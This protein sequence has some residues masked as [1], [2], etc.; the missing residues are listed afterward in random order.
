MRRCPAKAVKGWFHTETFWCSSRPS[1]TKRPQSCDQGLDFERRK[2]GLSQPFSWQVPSSL[3]LA[4]RLQRPLLGLLRQERLLSW[5]SPWLEPSW[6]TLLQRLVPLHLRFQAQH[7][8]G[9]I[10]NLG[11]LQDEVDDLFFVQR[12]T[13]AGDRIWVFW[14]NSKT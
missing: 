1:Q 4:F 14:K 10:G 13:Q 9:H 11:H 8:D 2:K 5:L 3:V 7:G 6:Q 12:C